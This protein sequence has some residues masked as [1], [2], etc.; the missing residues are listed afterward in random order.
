MNRYDIDNN[1]L[2]L[3][4]NGDNGG[5]MAHAYDVDDEGEAYAPGLYAKQYAKRCAV[6]EWMARDL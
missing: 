3:C 6:A 2:G 5:T 4:Y 1:R